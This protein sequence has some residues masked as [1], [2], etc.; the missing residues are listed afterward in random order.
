MAYRLGLKGDRGM[1]LCVFRCVHSFSVRDECDPADIEEP[2]GHIQVEGISCAAVKLAESQFYLFVSGS[3]VDGLAVIIV[4]VPFEKYLVH[5]TGALFGDFQ[6]IV[7]SR[8]LI[9]GDG[10]FVEVSH[11]VKFMAVDHMRIGAG[12]HLTGVRIAADM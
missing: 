11:V 10:R 2:L 7:L 1:L 4:R 9:I 8:G 6:K 5:V 3:L 12:P